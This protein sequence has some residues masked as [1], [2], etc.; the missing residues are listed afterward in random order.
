M[1]ARKTNGNN[2]ER[3]CI[4]AAPV[5]LARFARAYVVTRCGDSLVDKK[6]KTGFPVHARFRK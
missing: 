1:A 4:D 6:G 2:C 5:S 3:S